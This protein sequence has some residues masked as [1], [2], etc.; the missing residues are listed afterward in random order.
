MD[1]DCQRAR[2]KFISK[3]VQ[4]RDQL[5]YADPLHKVKAVQ[6]ICTDAYGC[7]LWDLASSSAEQFFKSWNTCVKL[8]YDIPRNTF[9]YLV[10]GYLAA[11]VAPLR[12]QVMARYA[13]FY[14]SLLQSPSREIRAMA[15]IVSND[16]RS[17]TCGNLRLLRQ[18]TGLSQPQLLSNYRVKA[19]LPVK[20]VPEKEVWRLGLL[21]SLLKVRVEKYSRAEDTSNISAMI[22]SICTT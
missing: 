22:Q 19:S 17:S 10:E 4:I 15:R 11:D 20:E 5:A 2:G 9:T 21:A 14:R 6:V 7:M 16:P 8:C 3:S 18:V 12:N 1:K 13:G